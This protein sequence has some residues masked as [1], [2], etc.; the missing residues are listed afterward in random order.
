MKIRSALLFALLIFAFGSASCGHGVGDPNE[1]AVI[2]TN[3]GNI[4]FEFLPDAAPKNVANFKKLARENFYVGTKF[5]KQIKISGKLIGIQGGDPNT[6]S[7]DPSTWGFGQPGQP[8]VQGEF[9]KTLRHER[10]IVSAVR[11]PNDADSATSQFV[12]CVAPVPG[13]DGQYTIF[14]KVIDGMNVVDL[15]S[16]APALGGGDRPLDPVVIKNV[17]LVKRDELK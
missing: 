15:I 13:W 2:E 12:I 1:V 10:G 11:N 17:R 8:R 9:S 4:V 14:A 3:Y 6:I 5:H 16:K 7:G